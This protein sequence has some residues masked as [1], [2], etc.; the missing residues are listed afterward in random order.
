MA[1]IR[2][3]I[4]LTASAEDVWA[5]LRDYGNVHKRIAPGFVT[6]CQMEGDDV[7]VVTFANGSTA[8][9]RLVSTDDKLRRLC[10]TI[11]SDRMTH[12]SASAEI[13]PEGKGCKFI[14][15]TDVLPGELAPYIDGQMQEGT[16][17]M[18]KTLNNAG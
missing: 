13:V 15:T 3:V 8:H 5:A 10:Y 1:T 14:W 4:Q 11:K 17:V 6:A 7:R 9:E 18:T 16:V 12:H 2:K